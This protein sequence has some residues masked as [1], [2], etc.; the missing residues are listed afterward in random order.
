MV[1]KI[2]CPV[3]QLSVSRTFFN[4]EKI[5]KNIPVI[6]VLRMLD[7]AAQ[8]SDIADA[9]ATIIHNFVFVYIF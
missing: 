4:K 8:S 2:P 3:T 9:E 6:F 5:C 1:T 7:I